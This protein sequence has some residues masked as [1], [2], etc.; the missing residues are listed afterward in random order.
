[1]I[2]AIVRERRYPFLRIT[3]IREI[4]RVRMLSVL[5]GDRCCVDNWKITHRLSCIAQLR[6]IICM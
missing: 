2:R 5:T 3:V 6:K 1:M 4:L